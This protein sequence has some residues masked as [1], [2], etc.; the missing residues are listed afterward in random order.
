M[1][2]LNIFLVMVGITLTAITGSHAQTKSITTGIDT[3]LPSAAGLNGADAPHGAK[4]SNPDGVERWEWD[5]S[6]GGGFNQ[7]L[8]WFDIPP[9]LLAGFVENSKAI[10][11][12]YNDNNGDSADVYRVTANW[13]EGDNGGDNI[14]FN[15]FPGGPGII[16]GVNAQDVSNFST[17][18]MVPGPYE[19]D[20]TV[21]VRAWASGE[22]N[23]GWGFLP[24]EGTGDGN[25][26]VSFEH[27][28]DPHPELVLVDLFLTNGDFNSD[29]KMNLT[30]FGILA[31]NFN[32]PG[33]FA[34]G[35]FDFNGQV[36]MD[37][38]LGFRRAFIAQQAGAAAS[39]PEPSSMLLACLAIG[40]LALARRRR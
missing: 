22:A 12:L 24:P 37:D 32:K 5:G 29:T 27:E 31:A 6:D 10:L 11:K 19:F 17:G 28:T 13:L 3:T 40:G 25:G 14:T 36:N 35:D 38:F 8:L 30:D 20:V 26:I 2:K 34:E 23:Y 16:P 7:G 4:G 33:S 18:V 21:D 15:G 9:G 1:K 39:I